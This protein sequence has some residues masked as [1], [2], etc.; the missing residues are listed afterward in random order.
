MFGVLLLTTASLYKRHGFTPLILE[1]GKKS[2]PLL[3]L[4]TSE[5]C[6]SCPPAEAWLSGLKNNSDLWKKFVPIAFHV[7]YWNS[8]GW[9]DPY[10]SDLFTKHQRSYAT[11]WGTPTVYTP[12]FVLNGREW[13]PAKL[14]VPSTK[15]DVGKLRACINAEGKV[16][17][18]FEPSGRVHG[19]FVAEASLIADGVS[20]SVP[21]GENAGRTLTHDFLSLG[22]MNC[23]LQ[24][25]GEGRHTGT[26]TLP[27]H[28]KVLAAALVLW[29]RS[30]ESLMPI[31]SLG[32]WLSDKH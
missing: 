30:P 29:V 14:S 11:A 12:E 26:F 18:T 32:G 6:S 19:P 2:T 27:A 7:D 13:R 24:L 8:L 21:R 28:A 17:V 20:T 3:E 15:K 25:S 9:P 1:S 16:E 10:S 5:G 4:Y 22:L 31:Q 23:V